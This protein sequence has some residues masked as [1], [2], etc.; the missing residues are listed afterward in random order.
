MF[1][2]R[3]LVSNVQK[4][5]IPIESFQQKCF[6][7]SL[8]DHLVKPI[9]VNTGKS[10]YPKLRLQN[11]KLYKHYRSGGLDLTVD[12]LDTKKDGKQYN[13]VIVAIHGCPDTYRTFTKLALHYL[14]S[15]VRV[16]APNLPDFTHTRRSKIFWHTS[17]EK[18]RFVRDFLYQINV[19]TVD[20]LIS[21][22][23]GIQ[24]ISHLWL[25]VRF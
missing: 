19:D 13:K 9:T 11:P 8:V 24:A 15:D 21:H 6:R 3:K 22:S 7:S 10:L 12:Y 17:E 16:I 14:D 5:T 4:C 23:F 1:V 18:S 25:K 2:H 20:C